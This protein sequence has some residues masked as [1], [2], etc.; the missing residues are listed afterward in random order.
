MGNI[1]DDETTSRLAPASGIST[2]NSS[3]SNIWDTPSSSAPPE[4]QGIGQQL[5]RLASFA[6]SGQDFLKTVSGGRLDISGLPDYIR[7]PIDILGSPV[8]LASLAIA[9]FTGGSSLAELGALGVG[10]RVAGAAAT[11]LVGGLVG[12][13]AG[14]LASEGAQKLGAP[15]W[16]QTGVGLGAGLLAGGVTGHVVAGR[17][18]G[19]FAGVGEA[20]AGKLAPLDELGSKYKGEPDL[21]DY[22]IQ[23]AEQAGTRAKAAALALGN[24]PEVTRQLLQDSQ[25]AFD[26]ANELKSIK[27]NNLGPIDVGQ[28]IL[29]LD[30]LER[31]TDLAKGIVGKKVD[32]QI[33]EASASVLNASKSAGAQADGAANIM[34][35]QLAG[36]I[37]DRPDIKYGEI[38]GGKA[39]QI[40]IGD[41]W[42]PLQDVADFP[43]KYGAS[44]EQT[45]WIKK[46][47][48]QVK[49][50]EDQAR[51]NDVNFT[52]RA[53][54]DPYQGYA[55]PHGFS[56]SDNISNIFSTT[57]DRQLGK[58]GVSRGKYATV[59]QG[60]ADGIEYP[61]IEQAVQD[62][63]RGLSRATIENVAVKRLAKLVD[64][65]GNPYIIKPESL[66]D[67]Q[68]LQ[69]HLDAQRAYGNVQDA[70]S[71]LHDQV[72][73][74]GNKVTN[75]NDLLAQHPELA[76]TPVETELKQAVTDLQT[77]TDSTQ[78]ATEAHTE[79][80]TKAS[81][82]Q[83]VYDSAIREVQY[84]PNFVPIQNTP[85]LEGFLAPKQ[86]AD[87]INH[88]LNPTDVL[89]KATEVADT[90]NGAIRASHVIFDMATAGRLLGTAAT[91]D[92]MAFLKG[93][94][95]GYSSIFSPAAVSRDLNGIM[96]E[97]KSATGVDLTPAEFVSRTGIRIG[98]SNMD[99]T[100]PLANLATKPGG[101]ILQAA[102]NTYQ[103]AL[104]SM[105][106][107]MAA[108]ELTNRV[109]GGA[110]MTD[111][112]MTSV[113]KGVN[114]V[115]GASIHK[116]APGANLMIQFPNW[117]QSQIEF[118]LHGA[119]GI[120]SLVGGTASF[121]SNYAAKA[122]VKMVLLGTGITYGVNAMGGHSPLD[123]SLYSNGVPLMRVGN[124]K[125]D[126]FGPYGSLASGIVA[127]LKGDPSSLLRSRLSPLFQIGWD[128]GSGS[129]FNG[130][131]AKF[132]DPTYW[133]KAVTPYGL[134]GIT[135]GKT[136]VTSVLDALGVRAND[137]TNY[138]KLTDQAKQT[139]GKDY[140]DLTGKEKQTLMAG[141]PELAAALDQQTHERAANGDSVAK[142][143]LATQA[144]NDKLVQQQQTLNSQ[145]QAG[146]ISSDELRVTLGKITQDATT[147]KAQ[148]RADYGLDK[149][150]KTP[151]ANQVALN[152][153][154]D[155]YRLSDSG[156]LSGGTAT[157]QIDW[158]TFDQ[159]QAEL[160]S[161]LTP[162][163]QKA[164]QDRATLQDPSL[165]WFYDNK[166]L[167]NSSGYFQMYQATVDKYKG[168]I[169]SSFPGVSTYTDL[170]AQVDEAQRTGN[171]GKLARA[172]ALV[173]M[174]DKAV[175]PQHNQLYRSNPQLYKALVD[176]GYIKLARKDQ[177]LLNL[178]NQ[179]S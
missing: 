112:L 100:G 162:E 139:M 74:Q 10:E 83:K 23:S 37:A 179:N 106:M 78:T 15:D 27:A 128:L 166:A 36:E 174:V 167:I 80:L 43:Y 117:A 163:Q 129:T 92:P 20:Q 154:Y 5:G 113:G 159:K 149:S 157:G 111:E 53:N 16:L 138:Q 133:A 24:S 28:P 107:H 152:Q 156:I 70:M 104:T 155:L 69:N 131:P 173:S 95:T 114:L 178:A 3:S 38:D 19:A 137:V 82:A 147:Q 52:R 35:T 31:L 126:V 153:Y 169:Q 135:E 105:R 160:M 118:L 110:Q 141:N 49:T 158:N 30:P 7:K 148:I 86:M 175:I 65:E 25:D 145:W 122:L 47:G 71:S 22:H 143:V 120:P 151:S 136:G 13:E 63:V 51:A 18:P 134:A 115:T 17:L 108:T 94:G 8:G 132:T 116:I 99:L 29:G 9:P 85:Q 32:P 146:K 68:I 2:S 84:N 64:P 59:A 101:G 172:N 150:L 21:L 75:L 97:F 66:I 61:P 76:G 102:S 33:R 72:S 34:A 67:N 58:N 96:S 98:D 14:Q 26:S 54:T 164:I 81:E 88:Q 40:K 103:R 165:K 48:E 44:A 127:A 121:E 60:L 140:V 87:F 177:Y 90:F 45:A 79:L 4:T 124:E 50:Y 73:T 39:T 93:L 171:I 77:S 119:A 55:L 6:T 125:I 130:S 170:K 56:E 11:G 109:S 161:S 12:G 62:Y 168:V 144:V 1:W 91:S 142:G 42:H 176:D 89:H 41:T 123:K 57:A 46:W